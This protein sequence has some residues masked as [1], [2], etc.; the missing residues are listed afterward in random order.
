MY[1]RQHA[2]SRAAA[3][4]GAA[5]SSAGSAQLARGALLGAAAALV[6]VLLEWLAEPLDDAL[7]GGDGEGGDA[8][9]GGGRG[10]SDAAR[11]AAA[12]GGALDFALA[13]A[14]HPLPS[15]AEAAGDGCASLATALPPRAPE[16]P[17]RARFFSAAAAS[18][19]ARASL[20]QL[21]RGA[22]EDVDD[23]A[24]YRARCAGPLL[25]TLSAE[26][27]AARWLGA[28]AATL[29][30]AAAA[31]LEAAEAALFAGACTSARCGRGAAGADAEAVARAAAELVAVVAHLEV[32]ART[33]GGGHPL[34]AAVAERAAQ[35]RAAIEACGSSIRVLSPPRGPQ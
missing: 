22:A 16:P 4:G 3:L 11:D 28:L 31:D 13:C 18:A 5:A 26:L 34:A 35:C 24:Q 30:P 21:R 1:K 23:V 8:L 20:A 10:A 32:A 25:S 9:G 12:L 33:G 19:I 6:A 14:A 7:A 27:G 15:A 2:A 29:R 17:W